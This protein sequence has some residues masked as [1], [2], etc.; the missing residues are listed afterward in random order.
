MAFLASGAL[1]GLLSLD[2]DL[3]MVLGFGALN[4]VYGA[5]SLAARRE[6]D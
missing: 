5:L 6:D 1:V 4:V 2:R 3:A